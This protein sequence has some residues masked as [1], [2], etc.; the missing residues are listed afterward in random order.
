MEIRSFLAFVMPKEIKGVLKRVS[1]EMI[2][3]P[4]NVRWVK[5]NH[6]HLT[7]IFIGNISTDYL[8]DLNET[9]RDICQLFGPFRIALK[10]VGVFPGKR[11]P[12]VLWIGLDGDIE[13]MSH[14]RNTLQKHLKPFGIREDK[15][16]FRP[17][18]TL[19]RF[20][21]NA[22]SSA[23]LGELLLKYENITSPACTLKELS[24]FKSDLKP[25]GAVYT[26][27]NSWSLAGPD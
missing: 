17:H 22:E 26:R 3:C 23:L 18:L 19:G 4:L 12:R 20:Q 2:K 6:T 16:R 27:L 13:R 14:F 10:G 7:V 21:K 11:S 24:L 1:G 15:R 9:V 8:D 25:S 5:V